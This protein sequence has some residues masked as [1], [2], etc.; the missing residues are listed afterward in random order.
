MHLLKIIQRVV[1]DDNIGCIVATL[2]SNHALRIAGSNISK[3]FGVYSCALQFEHKDK[4]M[5]LFSFP[6][7]V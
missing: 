6:D 1:S 2:D 5:V 3:Y 7:E 4:T